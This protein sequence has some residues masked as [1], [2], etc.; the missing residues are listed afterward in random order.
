MI[1]T[2]LTILVA[3]EHFYILYLEMFALN[4]EKAKKIFNLTEQDVTNPK[5]K[6][7]FANQGL[8]NG[9]LA[10]GILFSYA[11]GQISVTYFFLSCVVV[12]AIYG[13]VTSNK[14]IL[15]KQGLPAILALLAHLFGI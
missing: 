12:A 11:I 2:A 9:F 1:A 14:G 13:A 10:A 3:L 5:T 7:L 8:Y 4:T 15:I 6:I